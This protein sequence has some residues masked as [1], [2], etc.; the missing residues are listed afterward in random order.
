MQE[1]TLGRILEDSSENLTI[2]KLITQN[3]ELIKKI[4][5]L[6]NKIDNIEK[7]ISEFIENKKE[8]ITEVFIMVILITKPFVLH[9]FSKK[10]EL[11]FI[12]FIFFFIIYFLYF[13]LSI[14]LHN[15]SKKCELFLFYI[16]KYY[17]LFRKNLNYFLYLLFYF[18]Q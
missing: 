2:D 15:F 3:A 16:Y 4:N 8:E 5:V 7:L 12:F 6:N 13:I 17:V 10:C 18:K 1:E 9:V 14:L 11:F